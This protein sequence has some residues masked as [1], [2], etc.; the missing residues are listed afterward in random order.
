MNVLKSEYRSESQPTHFD[1]G[2]P[3][4]FV[5]GGARASSGGGDMPGL[6][7]VEK[8]IGHERRGKGFPG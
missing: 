3:G 1:E 6:E 7:E 8:S 5:F 2:N 4:N